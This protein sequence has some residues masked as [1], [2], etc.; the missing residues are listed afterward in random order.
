MADL[1]GVMASAEP[2][3]VVWIYLFIIIFSPYVEYGC[4]FDDL[5]SFAIIK[6]IHNDQFSMLYI[7]IYDPIKYY[8]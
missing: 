2:I 1:D 7:Y 3:Y 8:I 6:C 4:G 5:N